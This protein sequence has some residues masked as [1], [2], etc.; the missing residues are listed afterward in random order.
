LRESA[1]HV[2]VCLFLKAKKSSGRIRVGSRSPEK[3]G[4]RFNNPLLCHFNR[5]TENRV[6]DFAVVC[7]IVRTMKTKQREDDDVRKLM[8][9]GDY[10]YYV[11]L[12]KAAIVE[13]GWR[14]GQK[15]VARRRGDSIVIRDWEKM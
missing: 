5:G 7:T 4:M 8:R 6:L 1:T 10:S 14:R 13:L 12:P 9:V 15:L 11:T 3:G 2:I